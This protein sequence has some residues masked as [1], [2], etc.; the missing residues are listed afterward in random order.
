VGGQRGSGGLEQVGGQDAEG[1]E[2]R[3]DEARQQ[4]GPL[5]HGGLVR[6]GHQQRQRHLQVGQRAVLASQS[7][8]WGGEEGRLGRN[9]ST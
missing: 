9:G 5:L 4:T 8:S 6:V 3:G 1:A 2:R 7:V